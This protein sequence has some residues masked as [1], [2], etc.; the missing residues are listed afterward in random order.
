MPTLINSAK[1][2]EALTEFNAFLEKYSLLKSAPF[3]AFKPSKAF[4]N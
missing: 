4:K 1:C 3:I 2:L